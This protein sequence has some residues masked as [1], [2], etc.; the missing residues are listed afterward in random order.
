MKLNKE[1]WNRWQARLALVAS[2]NYLRE[3][4][5]AGRARR[6]ARA[7][8]DYD[9][10]VTTYF[11]HLAA[12]KSAKFH[13]DT[14]VWIKEH[15]K[16]RAAF[17]WARGHAKST[18]ISLLI[19]LWLMIQQKREVNML[20]LV[21]KS[22][23][24]AIALLQDIQAELETNELF[25]GDF[26]A[27]VNTGNW[28]ES[29]FTTAQGVT[30]VAIGR[31]QS[32]RGL[33]NGAQRPDYIVIDDI[34]D[35]TL[36]RN[37][38]R[39]KESFDWM[40]TALIGVMAMGRGRFIMVGNKIAKES[41]LTRYIDRP[42]VYHT[43]VDALDKRGRP[44][45]A[46]NYTLEEINSLRETMGE[47]RFRKEYMNDP[48]VEGAIFRE[49]DIRFGE[50][51]ELRKYRSLVCYTDPS[52]KSGAT[53]DYKAT[54][55]VGKT[56]EGVFHLLK[57]FAAQ[58][59]ITEMVEWHYMINDWIGGRVPVR[60]YMESNFIQDMVLEE[61]R[62]VGDARGVHIPVIGDKRKKPDKFARIEA[63]Q[64]LF[65]RGLVLFNKKEKESPGMN[66][67][68]EQLLS[69]QKGSKIHDD[70]PDALEGAIYL[71]TKRSTPEGTTYRVG[72]RTNRH[73]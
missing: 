72:E 69:F 15:P 27:Q 43:Q 4:E 59:T 71:L 9:Y 49:K 50:M 12:T 41:I 56:S 21:S 42:G 44:S 3:D 1:L 2:A 6:V 39:V 55:L 62:K 54:V 19:P 63:I 7:Q 31:G 22:Q 64:P 5:S 33:K 58:T 60:Y 23:D 37:P 17:M 45:W 25:I 34:D 65:E 61:F 53:N 35:D 70:A 24:A 14:A 51:L 68:V 30:F 36:C 40:M 52:F 67:L 48:Q 16:A 20:V 32:P 47:R 11:P 18:H 57:V 46:E 8:R 10:F 66:V 73:W 28:A 38:A 13:I 26:G 29:R